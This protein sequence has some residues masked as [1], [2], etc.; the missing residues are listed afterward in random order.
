MAYS[1][2]PCL[3]AYLNKHTFCIFSKLFKGFYTVLDMSSDT[4]NKCNSD[5]MTKICI[6]TNKLPF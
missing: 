3:K 6:S 2:C 4:W 5:M 1:G